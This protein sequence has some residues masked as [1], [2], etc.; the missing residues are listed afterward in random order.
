[1]GKDL[2]KTHDPKERQ[3]WMK[4]LALA[5]PRV[6]EEAWERI[7]PKPAYRVLRGPEIGLVMLRGRAA[8]IGAEFNLGEMTL[9]RCAVQVGDSPMGFAYIAGRVPRKAELAAI[10]DAL[11][12][13][14]ERRETLMKEL[15][16]P[17]AAARE[18]ALTEERERVAATRVEF[19]TMIRGEG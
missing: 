18:T 14:E 3:Y 19:F 6:L 1:M 2:S 5:S 9:T 17:L 13:E 8:G 11:L 12:Q 16:R 10:F 4:I 15:I 7:T